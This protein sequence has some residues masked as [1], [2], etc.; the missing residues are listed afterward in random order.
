MQIVQESAYLQV[1]N[2]HCKGSAGVVAQEIGAQVELAYRPPPR[3]TGQRQPFLSQL[4]LALLV[5]FAVFTC[6]RQ[7]W[8]L[9]GRSSSMPVFAPVYHSQPSPLLVYG[10]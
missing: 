2:G 3:G 8:A 9:H 5:A 4:E 7:A 10:R 6:D 1:T